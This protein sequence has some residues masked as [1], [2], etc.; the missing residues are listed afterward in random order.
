M[1]GR[2]FGTGG[3]ALDI[4]RAV[5]LALAVGIALAPPTSAAQSGGVP[6]H[7]PPQDRGVP[8]DEAPPYRGVPGV[9]LS[10]PSGGGGPTNPDPEDPPVIRTV[11]KPVVRVIRRT[12]TVPST[13]LN[14]GD[15]ADLQAAIAAAVATVNTAD[16]PATPENEAE[17]AVTA[18][19]LQAIFNYTR[20]FIMSDNQIST[21][22]N[23][24]IGTTPTTTKQQGLRDAIAIA[25]QR[26]HGTGN[27]AGFSG[28]GGN[29]GGDGLG[30]NGGGSGGGSYTPG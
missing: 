3:R 14:L 6:P 1:S 9:Y 29:A 13:G 28:T 26:N 27:Q 7:E 22:V 5:G 4:V 20:V 2:T 21:A 16:D 25:Q 19:T 30:N 17:L 23:N 15:T 11:V 10:A 8:D 12:V 24:V 18:A